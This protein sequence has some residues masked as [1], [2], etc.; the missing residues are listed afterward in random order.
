MRFQ[1]HN[2]W[3][4][5]KPDDRADRLRL[6]RLANRLESAGAEHR[7]KG[8]CRGCTMLQIRLYPGSLALLANEVGARGMVGG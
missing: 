2:S 5:F 8:G 3:L 4:V 6:F 1:V 7:L